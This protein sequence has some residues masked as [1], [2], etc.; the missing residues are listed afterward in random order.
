MNYVSVPEKVWRKLQNDLSYLISVVEPL[1]LNAKKSKWMTEE[2]VIQVTGLKRGSLRKK[3]VNMEFNW[4][5]A[6]AGR[7]VQYLRKDIEAMMDK[8]STLKVA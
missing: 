4:G 5:Y 8:N 3:R 1:A 7:K 2:E 6:G